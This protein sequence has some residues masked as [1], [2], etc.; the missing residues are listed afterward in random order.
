MSRAAPYG[1]WPSP[2]AVADAAAQRLSRAG[3]ASDGDAL[4]WL[5]SRPA[6]GGRTVLVRAQAGEEPEVVSPDGVSIRSRVHEYGGGAWCLLGA[7]AAAPFAYVEH[8][9]Q[10]VWVPA[11]DGPVA[12]SPEP[13]A[14]GSVHHGGLTAGPDGSVLC[15]RERL[16]GDTVKRSVVRLE[17]G[18]PGAE[19]TLCRG[20]DFFGA[21]AVAP[22][23][24][25]LAWVAWDHPDMPWDA[26]SLWVGS[27]DPGGPAP[28]RVGERLL[29]GC[30]VDQPVWLDDETLV[31]VADATGW[32]Q[33][34]L[35]RGDGDPVRLVGLEA[36]FQGPAW[37]LAQHT[38]AALSP[39]LLACIWRHDG[40]DRLGLV[41]TN[42][43]I[44]ELDQP[45]VVAAS[46]CA[47]RDGVAWLGATPT[48]PA[49]VWWRPAPGDGPAE[50]V[51][52]LASPVPEAVV[53]VAAPF[54][55]AVGPR[56]VHAHL[57]RPRNAE[58][59]GPDGERPPLV[60]QCHGGPTGGC[61]AGFDPVVQLLTTRGYAVAAVDYAGSTGYGRAYRRALEGQW[62]ATDVDDCVAVALALADAG[63]VDGHRMAIRGQS[64][65]GLT[66]LGALVRSRAFA[67][68]VAWYGVTDLM[69][70]VATT[71]DFE[72]RYTDR[73][74]G[75]L[76]EAADLYAERSPLHRVEEIEG[77]V[78][79]LQGEDDPVVP[80]DQTRA[81]V[82][83]LGARGVRVEVHYFAQESHGFRRA[84][85][86]VASFEAELDFY[87]SV[88]GPVDGVG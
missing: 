12:L 86:L 36:E 73:L 85:T 27:I 20:H 19:S 29:D 3:L 14:G 46:L 10:R 13:A 66:A 43:A 71:H 42:G 4:W 25:R 81:M 49:G 80:A 78:L 18:T 72:S 34:W 45:C 84:E 62:G 7:G 83:A 60:V 88:F 1:T 31:F 17:P 11:S 68:A 56:T 6:E 74:V 30:S 38:V 9:G 39:E 77:A 76:P 47:H 51:S 41:G 5:E 48:E 75:P 23:G 55:V 28:T 40:V 59:H 35:W 63:E 15:V 22:D 24:R 16:A 58:W 37:G 52:G 54:G 32:W 79:L 70:L 2:L 64:S 61:D 67:A 26:T 44:R 33:P 8:R 21:P 53:A 69:G 57:Y 65:G 82:A 87:R 50:R